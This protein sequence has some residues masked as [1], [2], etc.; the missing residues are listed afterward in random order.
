MIIIDFLPI[1]EP[2]YGDL[3]LIE[4]IETI[5]NRLPSFLMGLIG[6]LLASRFI[7]GSKP[8]NGLSYPSAKVPKWFLKK[9]L[10]MKGWKSPSNYTT[11]FGGLV[12]HRH[13]K[14]VLDSTRQILVWRD[15]KV[16]KKGSG[17]KRFPLRAITAFQADSLSEDAMKELLDLHDNV[18][19]PPMKE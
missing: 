11:D 12:S 16:R 2:I 10:R 9:Y 3:P 13:E 19:T 5:L 17:R 15:Q 7:F 8:E 1:L 4:D 18:I 14:E 6:S